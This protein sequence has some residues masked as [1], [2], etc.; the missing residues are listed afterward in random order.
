MFRSCFRSMK[1][2]HNRFEAVRSYVLRSR[3][4]FWGKVTRLARPRYILMGEGA[5]RAVASIS[6]RQTDTGSNYRRFELA[7]FLRPT[8]GICLRSSQGT[9]QPAYLK[10]PRLIF[11]SSKILSFA[12]RMISRRWSCFVVSSISPCPL[13]RLCHITWPSFRFSCLILLSVTISLDCWIDFKI[14]M[15]SCEFSNN[16]PL[17][18]C[19]LCN[20]LWNVLCTEWVR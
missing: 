10:L 19:F 12:P 4:W 2:I 14:L 11:L 8:R 17:K 7:V 15:R 6:R 5:G 13:Y 1:M 20:L 16:S 18:S 3:S 9:A